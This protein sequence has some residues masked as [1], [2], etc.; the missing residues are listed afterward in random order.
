MLYPP[1]VALHLQHRCFVIHRRS[2]SFSHFRSLVRSTQ[3]DHEH[4]VQL[5]NRCT[6]PSPVLSHAVSRRVARE[7]GSSLFECLFPRFI[8]VYTLVTLSSDAR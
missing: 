3:H 4:R 1:H 5:N 8:R 6:P 2:M 7:F